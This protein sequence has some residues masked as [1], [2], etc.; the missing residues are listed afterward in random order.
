MGDMEENRRC[1]TCRFA[2]E[3]DCV[4][5]SAKG[6]CLDP[7]FPLWENAQGNHPASEEV[8]GIQA[9]EGP[10]GNHPG[11][12]KEQRVAEA[13]KLANIVEFDRPGTA[14]IL[15]ALA[16][17]VTGLSEE[18]CHTIH[19]GQQVHKLL[20][21][22]EEER[23]RLLSETSDAGERVAQLEAE[24]ERLQDGAVSLHDRLEATIGRAE[25]AEA[26]VSDLK[27]Q[28]RSLTVRKGGWETV[29]HHR[30]QDLARIM[31]RAETAEA[32]LSLMAKGLEAVHC[33]IEQS[34][35]VYDLHLNGD[36]AP[37]SELRQGGAFEDWLRDFD[38][39]L[40]AVRDG[41]CPEIPVGSPAEQPIRDLVSRFAA[42]LLE[43]LIAAEAKYGWRNGWL[44]NDW[45]D[46][47]RADMQRHIEKGDPRDVAAYCA[48]MWHHGWLTG[49]PEQKGAPHE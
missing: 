19:T 2:E 12:A 38:T 9:S 46:K 1:Q 40:D 4:A 36:P 11:M 14:A 39:A 28:V 30:L 18:L 6:P 49:A 34:G 10:E 22:V 29:A 20:V 47:C 33:L 17:D 32:T 37:W 31:D 16:A 3:E 24:A 45:A 42:A 15:R 48:F 8:R 25:Y 26:R 13:L 44:R 43:K 35:G 27:A 7:S 41:N 21:M 23:D 5:E